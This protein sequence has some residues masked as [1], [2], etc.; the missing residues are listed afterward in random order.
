MFVPLQTNRKV[1]TPYILQS[2]LSQE[3]VEVIVKT[4]GYVFTARKFTVY[5]LLQYLCTAA[6]EEW[7]GYRFGA[8]RAVNSG[9]P[10]V[11]YSSFSNKATEVL[12]AVFKELFHLLVKK[13]NRETR[14][15]LTF[16]KE[17]LLIDS[18]IMT[19]ENHGCLGLPITVNEQALS[20]M[21]PYLLKN[22]NL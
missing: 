6:S 11:H 14:R 4:V 9:L 17:L 5:H 16:L 1:A 18:T 13:C 7:T 20:C 15:K 19:E 10:E 8:D 21:W 2:I 22:S 12:F 3:E